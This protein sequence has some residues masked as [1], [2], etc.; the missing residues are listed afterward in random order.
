MRMERAKKCTSVGSGSGI[1]CSERAFRGSRRRRTCNRQKGDRP[2]P[3][4]EGGESQELKI[5][6]RKEGRKKPSEKR[7][8][9]SVNRVCS[10]M[11]WCH[12]IV[13]PCMESVKAASSRFRVFNKGR[14]PLS[15]FFYEHMGCATWMT[16][17]ERKNKQEKKMP[18]HSAPNEWN[19][20]VWILVL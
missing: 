3:E 16:P 2:W 5:G 12:S 15:I 18:C 14:R 9:R 4:L 7:R 20:K 10:C 8:D 11:W 13:S 1:W 17:E 6:G 19:G